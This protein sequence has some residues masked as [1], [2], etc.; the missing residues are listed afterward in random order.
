MMSAIEIIHPGDPSV[1]RLT[2]RPIPQP[3]T[4]EVLLK[5]IAAGVNRPDIMQRKGL[6]PPPPGTT[7]IPGLEVSGIIVQTGE[8]VCRWQPGQTVCALLPGGGYAEYC[9]AQEAVCLPLPSTL[10]PVQAAA[11]PETFCTVWANLFQNG[12]LREHDKFLVHGGAGGIGTTAIQL[13][14]RLRDAQIFTTCGSDEKCRFCLELGAHTAINYRREDFSE[15]ISGLTHQTGVDVILDIIGA[16]YLQGNIK[17]LTTGGRLIIIAV[18]GGYRGQINL[19]PIF[20]RR[21]TLTG[22]TL[23]SRPL[24]E[25][26]LIARQLQEQVWPLL[27]AGTVRPIIHTTLPLSRAAEAHKIM[28]NHEHIGKIVLIP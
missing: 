27:E 16:P 22:S 3:G 14:A 20:L 28:E 18:Q 24:E 25:K 26:A 1:L 13:A 17:S 15:T 6:Y 23:R 5:V 9:L 8:G 7:D 11:L 4:G 21:L 10:N 2:Q 12:Q 19:L